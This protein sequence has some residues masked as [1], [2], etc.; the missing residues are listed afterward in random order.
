MGCLWL[1]QFVVYADRKKQQLLQPQYKQPVDKNQTIPAEVC[2]YI[3]CFTLKLNLASHW[4]AYLTIACVAGVEKGRR[5]KLNSSAKCEES[6]KRDRW[7]LGGNSRSP[8]ISR[9]PY[10]SRSNLTLPLPPSCTPVAQ[11]NLTII[12]R[13]RGEYVNSKR[14][15]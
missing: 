1:L 4:W 3:K 5:G 7:D 11:A 10:I 9:S 6:A 12:R 13:S 14:E 15:T 2:C 8:C